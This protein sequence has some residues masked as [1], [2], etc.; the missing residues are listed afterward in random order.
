MFWCF[1]LFDLPFILI[2]SYQLA[3]SFPRILPTCFQKV[4]AFI[5]FHGKLLVLLQPGLLFFP[6]LHFTHCNNR[7][8]DPQQLSTL[9]YLIRFFFEMLHLP[10]HVGQEVELIL[11]SLYTTFQGSLSGDAPSPL[12]KLFFYHHMMYIMPN[13][14]PCMF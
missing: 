4:P 11:S 6:Q 1:V 9:G 3:L 5:S 2:T 13:S 12:G 7:C 14:Y 10:V 8:L